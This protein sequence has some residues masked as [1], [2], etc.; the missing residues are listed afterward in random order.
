[1]DLFA[2]LLRAQVKFYPKPRPLTK[3]TIKALFSKRKWT[4]KELGYG[5]S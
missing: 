1:M 5:R 3:K 4:K 2:E